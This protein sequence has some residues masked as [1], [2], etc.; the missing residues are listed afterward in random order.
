MLFYSILP[1]SCMFGGLDLT[2]QSTQ[3]NPIEC[4]EL[5]F[6]NLEEHYA[7][8]DEDCD[9]LKKAERT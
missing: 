4:E 6:P 1:L 3:V 5:K 8:Q 9:V 7:K 2:I